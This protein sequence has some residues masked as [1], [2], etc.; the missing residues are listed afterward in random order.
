MKKQLI[1]KITAAA[2]AFA[3]IGAA[4]SAP[5]DKSSLSG[6]IFTAFA[7]TSTAT[8][9]ES[10]GVLTLHGNVI[11]GDLDDWSTAADII[12]CDEGTVF[13]EDCSYMFDDFLAE[14]IDLSNADTSNVTN[15]QGMFARCYFL[16][17]L[18]LSS[19]DTSNV[20]DM[21][22]MFFWC[23]SLES[24]DLS[25]FDTSNV[26]EM[27]GM[28]SNCEKLESLNL[29]SFDTSNVKDNSDMFSGCT[30]LE[31]S[32]CIVK[33]N[34]V[35][36]DGNIGVNVYLQPCENLS[37]VVMSGPN[38]D[39]TFTN[40]TGF[41]QDSG[42]YK[43]SYPINA[44]QGNE[45]ITLKAYDKDGK[46]LIICD[47]YYG[48]CNHSQVDCTVYGY[49]DQIK[50]HEMYSAPTLAAL[51]DGL[52]NYCKA[53]ENYFNGTSNTIAGI[54]NV[55]ADSVSTYAT[56]LGS[57]VKLSLVLNSVAALRLYTESDDVLIDD[58]AVKAKYKGGNKY[59]EIPNICAQQLSTAHKI[60]I[61][62]TDYSCS[63]LS[64]VHRV[65]NNQNAKENTLLT[66]M[67]KAT[68]VYAQA[69]VAY[70]TQ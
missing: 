68:Y 44:T 34:S 22:G 36:L 38:G 29:S 7:E 67:A 28:F 30:S 32:I 35:T 39:R 65:L 42:Y 14:D 27:S 33:G 19:F 52:E 69:A 1:K 59:Y 70:V 40:F 9:D 55:T 53:A 41:T 3:M 64:Y 66:A 15:M 10:T 61:G 26:T 57:D 31:P 47:N 6:S 63:A 20:T 56:D 25:S 60:T 17:S 45:Q 2:M 5:V 8:F 62:G 23:K 37:K 49:I 13:P 43:F 12:V 46:R 21:S 24:L 4:V 48:L 58:E 54:D 16:E 50:K 18:D 51:V 11:K